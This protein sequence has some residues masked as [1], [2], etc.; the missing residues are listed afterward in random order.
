ME[1]NQMYIFTFCHNFEMC[2]LVVLQAKS[3]EEGEGEAGDGLAGASGQSFEDALEETVRNLQQT[4]QQLEV[5]VC[6]RVC[7]SMCTCKHV[8]VCLFVLPDGGRRSFS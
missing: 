1:Q 8:S 7:A 6:V 3:K 5:C 4:A 2:K